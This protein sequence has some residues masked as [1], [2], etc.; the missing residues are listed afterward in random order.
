MKLDEIQT[1]WEQDCS[2]DE[3]HLGEEAIK[4]P[5]LHSKYIGILMGTKLKYSKLSHD[6]NTLKRLKFRYYRG[7]MGRDELAE[8]EWSQY[9]G[10]KPLKNELEQLLDGDQDV[11]SLKLKL[12]Y[13]EAIMYLLE[14]ILNQIKS[15]DWEI[16]TAVDWK[17]FLA[18]V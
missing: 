2:I 12:E 7:E 4:S 11:I 3:H 18:G 6:L 15:R 1:M 9:Q 17:K 5:K 13:L 16:K 8:L 14:S 10:V